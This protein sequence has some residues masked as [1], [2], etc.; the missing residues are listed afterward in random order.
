MIREGRC[1][2]FVE[3]R[4]ELAVIEAAEIRPR[5]HLHRDGRASAEAIG[6]SVLSVAAEQSIRLTGQRRWLWQRVTTARHS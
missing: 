3:K 1:L 2:A 6:P 5:M 4:E